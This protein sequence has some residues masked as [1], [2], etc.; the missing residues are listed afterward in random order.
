MSSQKGV[1][2]DAAAFAALK[3]DY[4][5]IGGGTGGLAVSAGLADKGFRVGVLEAGEFRPNDPLLD[6]PQFWGGALGKP[7]YDWAFFTTPQKDLGGRPVFSP[8]GKVLG[9][10]SA[11]NFL[12]LPRA[13][14]AEYDSWVTLGNPGWGWDDLVPYFQ[15]AETFKPANRDQIIPGVKIAHEAEAAAEAQ[16]FHGSS[17][18]IHATYNDFYSDLRDDYVLAHNALG[19]PTNRNPDHGNATGVFNSVV[20]V[21]R[22]TGKRSYSTSYYLKDEPRENLVILTGAQVT[23]IIFDEQKDGGELVARSVQFQAGGQL[24]AVSAQKEIILSAGAFQTPQVL[25]LSGIGDATL[26]KSVGVT[27]LVDLPA[28]GENLQDHLYIAQDWE[29]KD[30]HHTWDEL[31]NDPAFAAKQMEQYQGPKHDGIYASQPGILTFVP[32]D[33][34]VP[35][36]AAAIKARVREEIRANP[37]ANKFY[38][39]QFAIQDKWM[40]QYLGEIELIMA[41]VAFTSRPPK[42]GKSYIAM[43]SALQHPLSRGHVHINSSDPLKPP[44]ID[45]KYLSRPYDLEVLRAAFQLGTR[46]ASAPPLRD[47][48]VGRGTPSAEAIQ[49]QDQL[50][51]YIRTNLSPVFHPLG[52]AA[53]APRELGGVVSPKLVVYGTKNLRVVDASVIPLTIGTHPQLTVYAIAEKAV[54]LILADR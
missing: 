47:H 20:S 42:E 19:I 10:S 23:K 4:V 41:P 49:T 43:A 11:I 7:E 37:P 48:L 28:V 39:Q 44:T 38:A 34:A 17:G 46:V 5:V 53:M 35:S 3:F 45:P 9:G 8:R 40:D 54:D 31:R 52:T 13:S 32:L 33:A 30:G 26:L 22:S 14:K 51:E 29:L 6:T 2:T 1:I 12:M 24:L 50:D 25:E 15:K 16:R 18:A 21:D 36:E 27:P